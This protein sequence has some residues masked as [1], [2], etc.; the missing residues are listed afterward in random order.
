MAWK[1]T[2]FDAAATALRSDLL[3]R[4]AAALLPAVA[5]GEE[6][7]GGV[8]VVVAVVVVAVVAAPAPV[9]SQSIEWRSESASSAIEGEESSAAASFSTFT[10][11]VAEL[12]K[13]G[14]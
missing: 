14:S 6:G 2:F 5:V 3:S 13:Y 1:K 8:A 10:E 12:N 9:A 4:P 7:G 11:K